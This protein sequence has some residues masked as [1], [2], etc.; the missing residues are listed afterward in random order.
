MSDPIHQVGNTPIQLHHKASC[1]CGAVQLL[2]TLPHG[3]VE[4]RRC[5]CSMCDKRGAIAISVPLENLQVVKGNTLTSYQFN[6]M[7]AKHYFCSV[8]GIYTHHQR[9]SNPNEYG[10]NVA[11]LEGVNSHDLVEDLKRQGK[12]IRYAEGRNHIKD[13]V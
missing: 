13:K 6:T 7:T 3:L 2:L 5:D 1:H 11:S 4:A 9:R 12:S 10:V 8:C